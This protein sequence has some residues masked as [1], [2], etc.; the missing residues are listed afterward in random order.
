LAGGGLI[1][2][3]MGFPLCGSKKLFVISH[4]LLEPLKQRVMPRGNPS[5]LRRQERR[6]ELQWLQVKAEQPIQAETA[7]SSKRPRTS[8]STDAA[9]PDLA[10]A[11]VRVMVEKEEEELLARMTSI[12]KDVAVKI[13]DVLVKSNWSLSELS[14]PGKRELQKKLPK[15]TEDFQKEYDEVTEWMV[16]VSNRRKILKPKPDDEH[17]KESEVASQYQKLT[18]W[19][20]AVV[21]ALLQI[22]SP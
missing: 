15:I 11:A 2:R 4:C 1:W 19:L 5:K 3:L 6:Q 10:Q 16:E 18:A 14:A 12:R 17:N 8:D 22:M 20:D 13:V 7:S 9:K 21:A